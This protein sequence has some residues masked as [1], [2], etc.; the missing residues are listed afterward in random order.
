MRVVAIDDEKEMLEIYRRALSRAE[1]DVVTFAS[2]VAGRDF[3]LE[4][5]AGI[6]AV[7][8]DVDMP[9]LSG[10]E[11]LGELQERVAA[12]PVVMITGDRSA[13]TSLAALRNGAF[14]YL[15]KPLG[16]PSEIVLAAQRAAEHGRLRRR[17]RELERRLAALDGFDGIVG[18]SGPMRRVFE[19]IERVSDL[20]VGVLILGE[21]GSGKELVARAIHDRSP[22]SGKPFVAVNCAALPEQLVDSELF[23]HRRG[24]FTGAVESRP[25]AFTRA[26]HGTLFLDEI[27]DLPLAVQGRLLRVLQSNEYQPVGATRPLTANVRV[28]AATHVDLSAAVDARLF[29][30]DLYYRL[31]V[32][33]L[34]VPARRERKADIALLAQHFVTVHAGRL[35]RPAP[36][37]SPALIEAMMRY[38]WPGNVRELE[39]AIVAALALTPGELLEADAIPLDHRGPGGGQDLPAAGSSGA[40]ATGFDWAFDM[41]FSD[42]RSELV[43]RFE[44]AYLS[45]LL[46]DCDGNLSEVAR[47]AGMDRANLRRTLKRLDMK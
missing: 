33:Q 22:R 41:P 1:I 34:E 45:R 26:E 4:N 11:L 14:D 36:A 44:R 12:V 20:E 5:S 2:P 23:G 40:G 37:L 19:V 17:A 9:E 21:S 30:E 25:G 16:S 24:S 13:E 8:L 15:L 27:G 46:D 31:N 38:D 35:G 18:D 6:D 3:V 10:L 43:D 47:R 39:N 29:R 28:L 42:A 7:L 32:V